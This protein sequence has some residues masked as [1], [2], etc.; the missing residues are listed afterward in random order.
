MYSS[1][2]SYGEV[3]ALGSWI[4]RNKSNEVIM[5]VTHQSE[6]GPQQNQAY[7]HRKR[8]ICGCLARPWRD[9]ISVEGIHVEVYHYC[10]NTDLSA[11]RAT[12]QCR[13]NTN[14]T[15]LLS[16]VSSVQAYTTFFLLC[17]TFV[18]TECLSSHCW[19]LTDTTGFHLLPSSLERGKT[20][21]ASI[22]ACDFGVFGPFEQ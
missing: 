3:V 12:T 13:C 21:C 16:A 14:N 17:T 8:H 2:I 7:N 9:S 19:N 10:L 11:C 5:R 20:D 18:W 4:V 22:A 15:Q 1:V 6:T